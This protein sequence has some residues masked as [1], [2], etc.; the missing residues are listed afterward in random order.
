MPP[1]GSP[2]PSAPPVPPDPNASTKAETERLKASTE[3]EKAR[4]EA[5][6]AIGL[7][8]FEGKTTLNQGA[9]A[10]EGC[11]QSNANPSPLSAARAGG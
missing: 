4:A 7:P 8:S 10:I 9:G 5:I 6:K 3:L 2:G 11:C 1:A